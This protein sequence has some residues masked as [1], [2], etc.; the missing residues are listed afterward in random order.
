MS[1]IWLANWHPS[2]E[3][4]NEYNNKTTESYNELTGVVDDKNTDKRKKRERPP[5]LQLC[6]DWYEQQE[7]EGSKLGSRSTRSISARMKAAR[8]EFTTRVS[9]APFGMSLAYHA[10]CIGRFV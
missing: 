9:I 2:L 8:D 5:A 4:L 7:S 1:L 6:F 10:L 3:S